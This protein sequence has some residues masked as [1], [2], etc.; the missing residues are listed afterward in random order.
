M[1]KEYEDALTKYRLRNSELE[2]D[3]TVFYQSLEQ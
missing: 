3:I 1:Q 2:K